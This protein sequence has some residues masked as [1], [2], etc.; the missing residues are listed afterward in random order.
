M[1]HLGRL[2]ELLLCDDSLD[3]LIG[4]K[5]SSVVAIAPANIIPAAHAFLGTLW[6]GWFVPPTA[7]SSSPVQVMST[8]CSKSSKARSRA[9]RG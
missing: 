6:A 9:T 5:E 4:D 1:F 7:P 8:I 3:K 2:S